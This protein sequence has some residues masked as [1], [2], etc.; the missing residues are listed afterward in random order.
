MLDI[1]LSEFL[2]SDCQLSYRTY[3]TSPKLHHQTVLEKKNSTA[4]GYFHLRVYSMSR[5][6][7]DEGY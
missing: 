2:I 1:Y 4:H 5:L 6:L 7:F 3:I